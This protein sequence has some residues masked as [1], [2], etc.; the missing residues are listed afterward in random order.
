MDRDRGTKG[1]QIWGIRDKIRKR[2]ERETGIKGQG[3]MRTE[4]RGKR[5]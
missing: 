3:A 5:R 4:V 1:K 2:G